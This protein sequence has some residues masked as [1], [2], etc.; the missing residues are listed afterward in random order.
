MKFYGYIEN[1]D[2]K[3]PLGT[4]GRYLFELETV[5]KA[6]RKMRRLQET[7][8]P[9]ENRPKGGFKLFSYTNVYDLKTFTKII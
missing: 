5:P 4:T 6:V 7:F 2:G 3:E 1:E 9:L 8:K